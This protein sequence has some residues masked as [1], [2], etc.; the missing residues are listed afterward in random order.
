MRALADA[1]LR[2]FPACAG[3]NRPW[4]TAATPAMC[5]PRVR[6]DEPAIADGETIQQF[7][8]P[9]CA[10]MN[11]LSHSWRFVPKSVPRVR[12]DEPPY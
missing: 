2:V 6:G 3:M 9:A 11:R 1:A 4:P 12:G 10:G 7:V 5:V 8:F